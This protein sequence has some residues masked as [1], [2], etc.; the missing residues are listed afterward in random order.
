MLKEYKVYDLKKEPLP[1]SSVLVLRW[2]IILEK[3]TLYHTNDMHSQLKYWPRIA[4]TLKIEKE[5]AKNLKQSFYSFDV[6]DAGDR[7]H[8]LTE[9]TNGQFISELLNEADYDC[10]TIG[11]NEGIGNT[12]EQLDQLY[13][14]ADYTV[15]VSNIKEKETGKQP[16]WAKEIKIL[17]TEKGVKLG[18]IACTI[19]LPTSYDLLGW[20]IEEPLDAIA[21]LIKK[22]KKEVDGFILL[23]HLGLETDREI[24]SRFSEL[25]L[26]LGGHTHHLLKEGEKIN[27]TLIAGAGKFGTH[28]G[29]VNLHIKAPYHFDSTAKVMHVPSE[30]GPVTDE[31]KRFVSYS[32]RGKKNLEREH[33]AWLTHSLDINWEKETAFTRL[34]LEAIKEKTQADV[35]LLNAGLFLKELN[36]G[37]VTLNDLHEALPHPMRLL[38]I[39]IKGSDL[40]DLIHSMESKRTRLRSLPTVGFGFRGQIFGE[41]CYNGLEL[42]E[43]GLRVAGEVIEMDRFYTLVT[44]DYFLYV[45]FFPLIMER[46]RVELAFP[47]FLRTILSD[48]LKENYPVLHERKEKTNE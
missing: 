7:I 30:I 33:V 5:K 36:K 11:N 16:E 2:R 25:A 47:E 44:V 38:L 24:A 19:P 4:H 3:I 22:H 14:K 32:L 42:S 37:L 13:D 35:S 41:I 31:D 40:V 46:T 17:T 21:R 9:A 29:Q 8:P 27:Q 28:I 15:V 23:S 26:I 45:P 20:D 12:K 1:E 39:E 48:Y 34:A 10:V 6:G 18:V 43:N